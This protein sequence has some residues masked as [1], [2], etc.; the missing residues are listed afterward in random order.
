M[1]ATATRI[2]RSR[3]RARTL[4]FLLFSVLGVWQCSAALWIQAKAHLA[5]WLL[6]QA[7]SEQLQTGRPV[8]PW[9]WA[10]TW[11]VARLRLP[12]QGVEL[13]VL[14]G[15]S[16]RTLAFGPGMAVGSHAFGTTLISGHR[17]THF[18]VLRQLRVGDEVELETRQGRQRFRVLDGRVFDSREKGIRASEDAPELVL[19]T[20][21][22]FDA[23]VPGGPLRYR[24]RA[25][26][27]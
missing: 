18:A 23:L 15:D 9:P 11:P 25:L 14:Q 2:S 6:E 7:W 17:D 4:L 12:R 26:P 20:C 19:L 3:C 22:P 16:G 5:Q 8:R 27:L 24:I 10:D 1:N 21:Y 13:L